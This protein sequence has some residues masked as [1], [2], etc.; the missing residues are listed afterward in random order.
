MLWYDEYPKRLQ[1]EIDELE[2]AGFAVVIDPER[3]VAGQLVLTVIYGLADAEHPL[4]VVFPSNYPYFAFQVFAPT[5]AL[6]KHQDPISKLLCFVAHIDSEWNMA[7]DTVAK[8]LLEQLPEVL[9]ADKGDPSVAEAREGAP[10]TGFLNYMTNSL[11]VTSDWT[12]PPENGRGKLVIGVENDVDLNK[13]FRCAILEVR[14]MNGDVLGQSD[15]S[16]QAR[17]PSRF[18]ARWVRLSGPPKSTEP[19]RVLDEAINIWPELLK[20]NFNGEPDVVGLVFADQARFE[21]QHDIWLFL[22]RRRFRASVPVKTGRRLPPGDQIQYFLARADRG[23]RDDLQTRVPRLKPAAEKVVSVFGLGA[24]GSTVAWQLARAGIGRLNL[25]DHDFVQAGNIPRW[26][27]GWA[28]AGYGK[29][30]VLAKHITHN[31]P[32][33]ETLA[34]PLKVGSPMDVKSPAGDYE[35]RMARALEGTDLIIDCTVEFTVQNFLADYAWKHGIPYLWATGT[36]GAWGGIVG[37]AIRGKTLGCWRCFRHQ[38]FEK[39]IDAPVFEE[40]PTVQ[41]IGCFSPTFTGSG[42]DMDSVA[43]QTVR[44]AVATLCVGAEHGY[45]DF[46]W[47]VGVVNLWKDGHPIAPSWQTC[48]LDQHP[49]CDAHG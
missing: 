28:A 5:L 37:R 33:V 46:D 4:T 17:Y 16:I 31:Y 13:L 43:L 9:K 6:A 7:A 19:L 45:P 23:S 30:D 38:L 32:F 39:K 29:A 41:P 18:H 49:A 1:F 12:L 26:I 10:I 40:G 8:Y 44:M 11:V 2:K 25:I 15:L 20:P 24:L 36:P 27:M 48:P 42:F 14:D 35:S 21:E 47:D 22:V 3:R 34:I